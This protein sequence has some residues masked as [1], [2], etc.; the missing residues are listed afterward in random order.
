M[1]T[2]GIVGS[3]TVR[4]AA[5]KFDLPAL[6]SPTRAQTGPNENETSRALRKPRT[7]TR[8][9]RRSRAPLVVSGLTA[10]RAHSGVPTTISPGYTWMSDLMASSRCRAAA[11]QA[12]D[13]PP[14]QHF[15][16]FS[17]LHRLNALRNGLLLNRRCGIS[18]RTHLTRRSFL[19]VARAPRSAIRPARPVGVVLP[20]RPSQTARWMHTPSRMGPRPDGPPGRK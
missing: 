20:K 15:V 19:C 10:E 16:P 1:A 11:V 3:R 9:R 8:A 5:S 17:S 6:A 2:S 13:R 4:I 12:R 7:S 14:D 18:S